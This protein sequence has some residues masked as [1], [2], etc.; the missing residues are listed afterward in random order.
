M[1]RLLL[2][3][4]ALA[5]AACAHVTAA[6]AGADPSPRWNHAR[7]MVVVTTATWDSDH[8]VMRRYQRDAAAG[9]TMVGEAVPV[10]VGRAGTGWGIGLHPAPPAAVS[11]GD[12]VK[13]EGD[14]RA[15]AGVFAIGTAFGYAGS[16]RTGLPYAAMDAGDYCVDVSGS[17]YYNR[18]VDSA[19]VGAAAI[20]GSTE[21]MR[22]DLHADGDQRYRLGFVIEQNPQATPMGGSCIFGHLWKTPGTATAGCTAMAP[23]TMQSLL[24][25]L[26][27]D[28][29][30]VFVLLPD[31]E[32]A[33]LQLP[34]HLPE[35]SP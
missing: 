14:G 19:Q 20:E 1:P 12:P 21:P 9:W 26:R 7:Q 34:W 32:Y 15:P 29:A 5:V 18:I 10:V 23:A 11:A 31:A 33:Q 25:W 3:C 6:A 27:A 30:P 13:R 2:A 17:P 22:R 28:A 4:A 35:L 16:A 8:G 24:G